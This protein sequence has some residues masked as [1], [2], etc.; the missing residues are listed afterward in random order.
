MGHYRI[1]FQESNVPDHVY[2][3]G[4]G[5]FADALAEYKRIARNAWR[6]THNYMQVEFHLEQK[7]SWWK[8]RTHY[9]VEIIKVS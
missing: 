8:G 7:M 4:D 2:M 3:V 1:R 5:S 6:N 9:Y